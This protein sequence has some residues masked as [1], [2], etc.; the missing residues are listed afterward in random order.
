MSI[1]YLIIGILLTFFGG[2]IG[3]KLAS[4]MGSSMERNQ[5]NETVEFLQKELKKTKG[6]LGE[7]KRG[8][9]VP[10][11]ELNE[12]SFDGVIRNLITKYSGMAPKQFQFLLQDPA[13]VNFLISEA[14][15]NPEQ[16]KEVLSH[17]MTGKDLANQGTSDTETKQLEAITLEGA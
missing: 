3:L 2:A 6:T 8:I 13:I 7:T 1:V 5:L 12:G 14:K 16:A 9:S 17:F 15:K 10:D 11:I 4:R